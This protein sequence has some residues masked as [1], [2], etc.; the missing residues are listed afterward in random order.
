MD[1]V[2]L[3]FTINEVLLQ[4]PWFRKSSIKKKEMIKEEK[5]QNEQPIIHKW[6]SASEK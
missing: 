3:L 6:P 4:P 1:T 2:Y 5:T